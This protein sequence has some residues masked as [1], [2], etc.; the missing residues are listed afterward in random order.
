[1][2]SRTF[3]VREGGARWVAKAVP[4]D[5]PHL[6]AFR[7]GL[8]LAVRVAA[9]GIP[10]G[11]P[12]AA[13]GGDLS[14]D[15]DGHA[16]ALLRWLGGEELTGE[17]E[18]DLVDMGATL[19]RV[20]AVLRGAAVAPAPLGHPADSEDVLA[21]RPWI[22]PALDGVMKRLAA[23]DPA[24]LTWGPVHGDP[25]P[26]AFR[27][28][29]ATGVCGLIDWGAAGCWPLMYDVASAV[30][31]GGGPERAEPLL[32]A[33][34][35]EGVLAAEEV[36]RALMPLLDFR[37]A[38]H[39]AYYAGRILRGD[40]TGSVDPGKNEAELEEARRWLE[41]PAPG[42]RGPAAQESPPKAESN[43]AVGGG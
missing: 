28:D 43:E 12:V 25:A 29:Q 36:E 16:V 19:G 3:T 26:E 20:H 30:L 40:R 14:V 22:R 31:Y 2:N 42:R 13:F 1:M 11:A 7:V 41:G 17:G 15:V 24:T 5:A 6:A 38:I 21:L 23:L 9:A 27:R 32:R 39:A 4:L 18:R 10:T 8:P 33:Y 35:R 34:L 37:Y